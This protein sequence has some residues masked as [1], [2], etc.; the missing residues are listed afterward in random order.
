YISDVVLRR[1]F[2]DGVNFLGD[3]VGGLPR[4]VSLGRDEPHALEAQ[5]VAIADSENVAG[6]IFR[7]GDGSARDRDEFRRA[8]V[9]NFCLGLAAIDFR[10]TRNGSEQ[11]RIL[12]FARTGYSSQDVSFRVIRRDSPEVLRKRL[13]R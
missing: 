6:R 9:L 13:R 4:S 7:V 2:R 1:A 3:S 8:Y 5:K 10:G 11:D 12:G